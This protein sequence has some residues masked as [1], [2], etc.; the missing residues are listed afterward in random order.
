M[1]SSG[2]VAYMTRR[3]PNYGIHIGSVGAS[4]P[5][6][7]VDMLRVRERK[8]E[9]VASFRSSNERK[10]KDAGVPCF[11][12]EA[13][14]TGP[15]SLDVSM[16]DGSGKKSLSAELVFINTGERPTLPTITGIDRVDYLTSSTIMEL[17]TV[18]NHLLVMGGGYIGIEFGQLFRRL[19]SDV[20]I[21]QR[22]KQLLPREDPEIA[23]EVAKILDEE[24]IKVFLN[25]T[26]TEVSKQSDGTIKLHISGSNSTDHITG[27]HLLAAAGRT[28]NSDMLNLP[29]AGIT[30]DTKKGYI[31]VSPTLETN[32][33][34]V[35]ALGDV[36]GPP[37]FTHISYN[38][39][40]IA[41]ANVIEKRSPQATITDRLVP[42]TVF[43]DPQLGHVGM[44][45]WEAKAAGRKIKVASIPMTWVARALEVDESRGIMKA[46]VDAQTDLIIG[47]TCL[48][49]EGGEIMGAVQLAMMGG[50]K[51]MVL[52]DAVFAHPTIMEALNT[53]WS[54]LKA[55]E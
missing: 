14:F 37:A 15:K 3:G 10:L 25:T 18:P 32:I 35:Y 5:L 26:A 6:V 34:G 40:L 16:L 8:R 33:P 50:L 47:F 20:T 39:F 13:S 7:A 46:V 45:E 22:G 27:S 21:I 36:K 41:Q 44:H 29:A 1:I 42:Y 53:L 38:D 23:A 48:G 12:G 30:Y 43:M 28:A 52:R 17:D 19:G 11:M 49:M 51:W 31:H 4:T 2:R 9:I 24:G 54:T 55:V